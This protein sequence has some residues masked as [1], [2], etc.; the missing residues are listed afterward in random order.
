ML[1]TLIN[2][3]AILA[4]LLLSTI[5]I[6]ADGPVKFLPTTLLP[7]SEN[8]LAYT[9][10]QLETTRKRRAALRGEKE[11]AQRYKHSSTY[12]PARGI[13]SDAEQATSN[14]ALEQSTRPY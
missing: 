11:N 5:G 12:S 10:A 2:S 6:Y 8:Q 9:R 4:A 14:N 3:S 13:R 7:V 1:I